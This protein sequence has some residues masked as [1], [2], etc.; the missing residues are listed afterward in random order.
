MAPRPRNNK[1][2][3]SLGQ[4]IGRNILPLTAKTKIVDKIWT[5]RDNKKTFRNPQCQQKWNL[6]LA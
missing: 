5:A 6:K 2:M 3:S 1:K 4:F